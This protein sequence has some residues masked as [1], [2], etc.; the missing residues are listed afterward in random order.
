M[1]LL[2]KAVVQLNNVTNEVNN[3]SSLE[4]LKIILIVS[5]L[6]LTII[7]SI[8]PLWFRRLA[9]QPSSTSR[10]IFISYIFS[11]LSCFGGGVF[12]GTCIL[13]L[14]PDTR[15]V[16]DGVLYELFEEQSNFPL[17]EF[18]TAIGFSLIL[19]IEQV[20]L[21]LRNGHFHYDDAS[22]NVEALETVDDENRP[23]LDERKL[24]RQYSLVSDS[25][26]EVHVDP[27]SHSAL[28]ALLM[29]LT[30]ST[31][32]LFEGL[33]LGLVND[34]TQAVQIFTALS[35]HKSLVGFSLGLRL[36]SFSSLSNLIIVLSCLAFS[37]TGCLGGLIGLI[38][39]ETL[40]SKMA[41]IITG[42][43]QGVACG[44]FL[45]I[46]TF[47]ILPH[48]LNAAIQCT[49]LKLFSFILGLGTISFLLFYNLLSNG[50]VTNLF[51]F[52]FSKAFNCG[53][54]SIDRFGFFYVEGLKFRFHTIC[55]EVDRAWLKISPKS[56]SFFSQLLAFHKN[57]VLCFGYVRIEGA[58][59]E[60]PN[61]RRPASQ[62]ARLPVRA[63]FQAFQAVGVEMNSFNV[64]LLDTFPGFLVH[65]AVEGVV[66]Y[67]LKTSDTNCSRHGRLKLLTFKVLRRPSTFSTISAPL[68]WFTLTS[69]VDFSLIS[70]VDIALPNH[71]Q[72]DFCNPLASFSYDCIILLCSRLRG[73]TKSAGRTS[74]DNL[75]V[76]YRRV[77]LETNLDINVCNM[78][79]QFYSEDFNLLKLEIMKASC[80]KTKPNEKVSYLIQCCDLV[81]KGILSRSLK[82]QVRR[83]EWCSNTARCEGVQNSGSSLLT[84]DVRA[85]FA[86]N[87]L[88]RWWLV[89][90]NIR[91]KLTTAFDLTESSDFEESF[92]GLRSVNIQN[93]TV[94]L[95]MPDDVNIQFML[96]KAF[97]SK[98]RN[99]KIEIGFHSFYMD[100]SFS[101]KNNLSGNRSTPKTHVWGNCSTFGG[102]LIELNKDGDRYKCRAVFKAVDLEY[103]Q[104]WIRALWRL[105][106][107]LSAFAVDRLDIESQLKSSGQLL[108]D[109]WFSSCDL[110]VEILKIFI[111]CFDVELC[112]YIVAER[113]KFSTNSSKQQQSLHCSADTL[114]SGYLEI[115]SPSI[116]VELES[117]RVKNK[118]ESC[119][120]GFSFFLNR[121]QKRVAVTVER[122]VSLNWSPV[123][124]M[125]FLNVYKSANA[126]WAFINSDTGAHRQQKNKQKRKEKKENMDSSFFEYLNSFEIALLFDSGLCVQFNFP[127]QHE[128]QFIF[129]SLK[130][131]YL[132][133]VPLFETCSVSIICDNYPIFQFEDV[134]VEKRANYEPL[135]LIRQSN[136]SLQTK[137]NSCWIWKINTLSVVFPYGYRFAAMHQ[138]AILQFVIL[139]NG[140]DCCTLTIPLEQC[141][142]S[143][144]LELC[145]DPFEVKL[146]DNYMLMMDECCEARRRHAIL[147]RRLARRNVASPFYPKSD[148]HELY[149]GLQRKNAS[150]YIQRSNTL[151]NGKPS[152]TGLF[153]WYVDFVDLVVI[154]DSALFGSEKLSS[155]IRTLDAD[156]L[157]P[158]IF[159]IQYAMRLLVRCCSP[160]PW[161]PSFGI[162]FGRYVDFHFDKLFARMRDYPLPYLDVSDCSIR[163]KLI[164]C[165]MK[166]DENSEQEFNFV[167]GHK[168]G[169]VTLRHCL[170]LLKYFY[171]LNTVIGELRWTYGPC[172]DPCMSMISA[173]LELV[174]RPSLD[175]S[176]RLPFW[177][178]IRLLLHGRLRVRCG[179]VVTSILASADPYNGTERLECTWDQLI[180]EWTNGVVMLKCDFDMSV[181]TA[182]KYDDCQLLHVPKCKMIMRMDWVCCGNPNNHYAVVLCAPNK[183]PS[184]TDD[185]PHDSYRQFRSSHLNISLV[186]DVQ[187]EE[188]LPEAQFYTNTF[189]WLARLRNTISAINRPIRRGPLYKNIRAPRAQLSR[190]YKSVVFLI[191]FPKFFVTYRPSFSTNKG[192][193]LTC[194][195]LRF[196]T[197]FQL[198][199]ESSP[200]ATNLC[201]RKR[202]KIATDFTDA[203]AKQ[204]DVHVFSNCKLEEI[205]ERKSFLI[206]VEK[207][208][209]FRELTALNRDNPTMTHKVSVYN[210]RGIWTEYNRDIVLWV[211]DNVQKSQTLRR[212][213]STQATKPLLTGSREMPKFEG[214]NEVDP[215]TEIVTTPPNNMESEM[216][217]Q[218]ITES[219]FKSIAYCEENS[220]SKTDDLVGVSMSG[221][222]DVVFTKWQ[223]ELVNVQVALR[224]CNSSG[225][226]LCT[227]AHG[228]LTLRKH[229]PAWRGS[230]L[231]DKSTLIATLSG[232]QYFATVDGDEPKRR[233]STTPDW[234]RS[235][236]PSSSFGAGTDLSLPVLDEPDDAGCSCGRP[237]GKCR[238]LGSLVSPPSPTIDGRRSVGDLRYT[239]RMP[240]PN[241]DHDVEFDDHRSNIE[242]GEQIPSRRA[243][244]IQWLTKELVQENVNCAKNAFDVVQRVIDEAHS[245]GGVIPESVMQG[246]KL[247]R[248]ISRC[249]C[250]VRISSFSENFDAAELEKFL[251][252]SN[253]KESEYDPADCVTVIH[254]TLTIY[255]SSSQYYMILDIVNNLILYVD[256]QKKKSA[257]KLQ[258]FRF[259]VQLLGR[260]RLR[261][262]ILVL[263]NEAR[264]LIAKNKA[265]ELELYHCMQHMLDNDKF[266]ERFAVLEKLLEESKELLAAKSDDLHMA[267]SCLKEKQLHRNRPPL[268]N[269]E[270]SDLQSAVAR[271]FEVSLQEVQWYL[272]EANGQLGLAEIQLQKFLYTKVSR[273]N[274]S[275]E[276][277]L[278]IS[279]IKILNMLPNSPF[280]EV[281][282]M[283]SQNENVRKPAVSIMCRELAPVGGISV[284]EHFEVTV[285]PMHVMLTYS[286][287]NAMMNFF[288]PDRSD[289]QHGS[290]STD[291]RS[292]SK[293][294]KSRFK[295]KLVQQSLLPRKRWLTQESGSYLDL[296]KSRAAKN[297]FFFNIRVNEVP[298]N[299]TYRGTKS[300]YI[301]NFKNFDLTFPLIEYNNQNW[302]WLDLAM[303]IKSRSLRVFVNQVV[304]RKLLKSQ[305]TP[306]FKRTK[307]RKGDELDE[308]DKK[309]IV[310]GAKLTRSF[311]EK[312]LKKTVASTFFREGAEVCFAYSEE[313]LVCSFFLNS[314]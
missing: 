106:D 190:H 186:I 64:A 293:K 1:L 255:T 79:L 281:L 267:I 132:D 119:L 268:G 140:Y 196:H 250:E 242:T 289:D 104:A 33:A 266:E 283:K 227:A 246:G 171:D 265:R 128:L 200:S 129:S 245:A 44:T 307:S 308:K 172:W 38:L 22:D 219:N 279:K 218:L 58:A 202:M 239:G 8:L 138:Q 271:R 183:L 216:L 40:R 244:Q 146:N 203:E 83:L 87:S 112:G 185:Q 54:I 225:Y 197:A 258:K 43:L 120:L 175:P 163:G 191:K 217:E 188:C 275:G 274:D 290:A 159:K 167:V 179:Q 45:Y 125:I 116:G 235:T 224:G 234:G 273:I 144:S 48:E 17:A 15:E 154:A 90:L 212:N 272:T 85:I 98:S 16:L 211:Y 226:L 78:L 148:E 312:N 82:L 41:K 46:V 310:L 206:G 160:W 93:C 74:S 9:L 11:L 141:F 240:L 96:A 133:A 36:V 297:K 94:L 256:P 70:G 222:S 213:L 161:N 108:L 292:S 77:L 261:S 67:P 21:Y 42:A 68:D 28:R 10:R 288:F 280:K 135:L 3:S 2:G 34:S 66:L 259:E 27:W 243:D 30:L 180:L 142:S 264:L 287:F 55:M 295:L 101:Y 223:I 184:R 88:I 32:A 73:V 157:V 59:A 201:R 164:G 284:L 270:R 254:P 176:P 97:F 221:D 80:K 189:R 100:F 99:S 52:A 75:S 198:H 150:I 91:K 127:E 57:L 151:Y 178:R 257:E 241:P 31:H 199:F 89:G 276:H 117:M 285:R 170:A 53:S 123:L 102:S 131:A 136:K 233:R 228:K 81:L 51:L 86:Y 35:I 309:R 61:S 37:A 210:V 122:N 19:C 26:E 177:D 18:F 71:I 124:H 155:E 302:T 107:Q 187:G 195:A 95:H 236:S 193:R 92:S 291:G 121:K 248:I 24:S 304:K 47:E 118:H 168:F 299:V 130:I 111:P 115:T 166:G 251:M 294:R 7:S 192:V 232:M 181:R 215:T 149:M 110:S 209:Y 65:L 145:D 253:H 4:K 229:R 313:V 84:E 231:L 137:T 277:V 173:C 237:P 303:A 247:Q 282:Q 103:R 314:S 262:N 60:F 56:G 29:L 76:L 69:G 109:S 301:D 300:S 14:L 13:D 165:E 182:S 25:G 143:F 214:S 305:I 208:A 298:M 152:R 205:E 306:L 230:Q 238:S 252:Q 169:D 6:L 49:P 147:K 126:F 207:L 12:L 278:E 113:V 158:T 63:L 260:E 39:S 72:F 134:T 156:R 139:G 20:V 5:L 153:T 162:L 174:N 296:M 204:V 62:W 249:S 311:S 269:R 50:Q 114:K 286:F 263:Q 23:L 194:E 105:V 220:D